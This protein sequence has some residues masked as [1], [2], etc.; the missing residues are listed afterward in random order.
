M[1]NSYAEYEYRSSA[2]TYNDTYLWQAVSKLLPPAPQ[3]LFEL[4]CGNG[5]LANRLAN[6]GYVV[7]AVDPSRSGIIQGKTAYPKL[8]LYEASAYDDLAGQF[9][10]FPIVISLEV[11]EHCY[12]PRRYVRTFFDLLEPGG[13]GIISTPYHG[14]LKNLAL[15]ITGKFDQHFAVLWDG[16]HIKFFSINTLTHLLRETG[17]DTPTFYRVGRIPPL[18]KSMI[19]TF[20]K[21][22]TTKAGR[23]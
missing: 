19:A 23:A 2:E 14:Y 18:A 17:F 12:D 13:I 6:L 10:E 1:T 3:R 15:A 5:V 20:K 9:G 22:L 11:I 4:G 21:P 16:G 7:T 8:N